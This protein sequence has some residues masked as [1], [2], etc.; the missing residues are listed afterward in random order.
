MSR[1]AVLGIVSYRVFPA[2]MGGQ[3][4]VEGFYREL[5]MYADVRLAVEKSNTA[6]T[7]GN[8]TVLPFLFHHR[9][10]FLN[11]FYLY[12]LYKLIRNTQT[13]YIIIEHSYLG[14]LGVL[15]QRLTKKAFVIRSH[16]IEGLR[17]RDM[18]NW[19]WQFY[20]L[21]EKAVHRRADKNFF[22]TKEEMDWAIHNWQLDREKCAVVTYGIS[23]QAPVSETE[24]M[25]YRTALIARHRLPVHT[26]LFLFN[27]TLDYAPN[28]DAL[29]IILN[30]L[31]P[32]LVKT[33]IP[34]KIIICGTRTTE[35]WKKVLQQH[36]DILFEDFSEDIAVYF[37]GVDA[38]INP[39]TLGT[40]IKIKLVDALSYNQYCISTKS[41]AK[42]IPYAAENPRLV[43]IDDYDWNAFAAAMTWID[44][45]DRKPVPD[46]FYQ[47]F[48]GKNIVQKALLSL[49]AV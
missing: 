28:T 47:F 11:L 29:R 10:G 9:L 1:P 25:Q 2:S 34:F 18:R 21:Y 37:K 49:Q 39:V 4:C 46:S 5:S 42:G 33:P 13:D 48:L 6:D 38:F 23:L 44:D 15:L 27:G 40:G 26:R 22:I 8:A 24:R 16:N 36:P 43:L 12:K 3:K 19:Y 20:L 32:R 41:G 45:I 35:Q 17:F 31:L 30:E 14:W 7:V